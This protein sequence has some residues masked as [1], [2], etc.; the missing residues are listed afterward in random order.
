MTTIIYVHYS[1][2]AIRLISQFYVARM[3]IP[4]GVLHVFVRA[5]N[6]EKQSI[7]DVKAGNHHGKDINYQI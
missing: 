1:K 5:F 4:A 2:T 7:F 6:D 3:S